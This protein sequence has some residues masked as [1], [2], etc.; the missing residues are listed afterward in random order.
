MRKNSLRTKF[1]KVTGSQIFPKYAITNLFEPL[2]PEKVT[3]FGRKEDQ[4]RGE[5]YLVAES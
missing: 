4:F 5:I 1:K 2:C 3:F